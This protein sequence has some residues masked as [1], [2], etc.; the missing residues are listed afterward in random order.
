V[1]EGPPGRPQGRKS[2]GRVAELVEVPS[3]IELQRG[4][5]ARFLQADVPPAMRASV[6][7]QRA[8]SS[9]FPIRNLSETAALE[10]VGYALDPPKN[11]PNEC[12]TRGLTWSTPLKVTFRLVVWDPPEEGGAIR[13]IKEQ[14]V[15]LG[16]IPL[17]TPSGTFIINGTERVV[18]SQLHRSPGI[19][20][21][22]DRGRTHASG[23]LLYRARIIPER[24][25]WLDLEFDAKD[26]LHVR[27]DRRRKIP[28][29]V[30][31]RALG[32]STEEL[33]AYYYD[34]ETVFLEPGGHYSRSIR[35]DLLAGRRAT[36]DIVHPTT[37]ELLVR[38]NRKFTRQA[39]K[40]LADAGVDRLPLRAEDVVG[41]VAA[42]D[43][44]DPATGEV[45]LECNE[46]VR[47]ET[48]ELLRTSGITEFAVLVIDNLNVGG[49]VRNT[50]LVDRV[51]TP[52][53]ALEEF[54]RR[55]RPGQ[56]P[57]AAAARN[58]LDNLFFS[59]ARYDLSPVGRLKLNYKLKIDE[60]LETSTLTP[61]DILEAV[62]YLTE[63]RDG[64]G[65]LDDVDHLGNRR[66]RAVGELVERQFRVGLVRMERVIRERM[67]L[68]FDTPVLMPHDLVN[69][70]AVESALNEFFGSSQLSQ[71]ADQ[72]NPL[73]E[74]THKRR[75]SALGPG[76]LTR[77]Y[78]GFE[79]R[80]VHATHY[81]RLCPIETP[82]GQNVGLIVSLST[83][84]RVNDLG[85]IETP[86]RY[87][88]GGKPS[89]RVEFFSALQ[90]EGHYIAQ[91]S[92]PV[93]PDG[94]FSE[95]LVR[96]RHNG[97]FVM[98]RPEQVTL[99]DTAPSQLVSIAAALIPFL[100]HDDANRAL[101]GSNMQRQAM[102]LLRAR[103]PLV[104]TGMEGVVGRDSGAA[105]L[106]RRPGVVEQVEG[107]TVVVRP[108]A[109][110]D[111]E[112]D[113][114]ER[115][116]YP[117]VK[118][119]RSNQGSCINQRPVVSAGEW[120][121]AG[122]L[123]A[124]G[125]AMDRGELALGA[126]VVVA[127]MPWGGYNFEDSILISERLVKEDVLTSIHIEELE[128]AA[129]DTKLG[130]E[131]I[132][133]DIPNV[134]EA[135]LKELDDSGV[136]RIGAE[137]GAG[138]ILVGKVTPKG[139]TVL[140][141]E[142]KLLRAI[143]GQKAADVRDTSLRVPPGT[144][145]T[146][147]G[148]QVLTR[149]E[150]RRGRAAGELPPGVRMIVKV[151]IA[152]KRKLS[153]GDKLAGRHGNK[154]V[155]S[156]ILP[157]EDMPYLEDGTPVDIVLNP[158]GVPSRMNIGQILETHLGW[159]AREMGRALAALADERRSAD[160][161]RGRLRS[162][163]RE[164]PERRL[165]DQ[166]RAGEVRL[167][168]RRLREGVPLASP[169]FDGATEPDIKG[170]LAAAGL[171]LRGQA[172][173][174]D[175]RTG[176]PF[177]H[178]VTVGIMYVMKLHHLVDEKI[179]ARSIGPYSLVTQQPLGGKAQQGGQRLG[180]MEVWAMEGYGAAHALQEFLTVKSDDV[181]GRARTYEA[182]VQGKPIVEFG[183]P[184]SFHVLLKELQSLCLD[185][186]LLSA[187]GSER[188]AR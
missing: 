23:K 109:A 170:L 52:E 160:E 67:S 81:G 65:T 157:E 106:A 128:C 182:I 147:I 33:L 64:R 129:R 29:T 97:D 43:V 175:G 48:L 159:A 74:V 117:I 55:M 24:G 51:E 130:A 61:R 111:Q 15:L 11:D 30:L 60:P 46:A 167:W 5:Y 2:F 17:M 68:S 151:S 134:G 49:Y 156:R 173:V 161:L 101:M 87:V 108:R 85:F 174:F 53:E 31:L 104:G 116:V 79:V 58:L 41:S 32:Y 123:L 36:R 75:L 119:R 1:G 99:M 47:Q 152:T 131:E 145:G 144:R 20:Y 132:T 96:C 69:P 168:A 42:R 25:S 34:L 84:A 35:L 163:Y 7:L 21:G 113:Q 183:L 9:V 70:R 115:D 54:F 22:H 178:D 136:V 125:A 95:A 59:P 188:A 126:N 166:L 76:G 143:F 187:A 82:E 112:D 184:E 50:V 77:E 138:D 140:S 177:K 83:H 180:E 86:Y 72:T 172:T 6:G 171:P 93:G 63:L 45:L 90:E 176:E 28:A 94:H 165:L 39:L 149:G 4:S 91:A 120:V 19:F 56:V 44:F 185:V 18:V 127:F 80:D 122:A 16:E 169:V 10:F 66:V 26:L 73:S 8:F 158:L 148:S 146:V 3:L 124:D 57:T 142:E 14:E 141:P 162:V 135:A 154:G 107:R 27:V 118:F 179:H 12:R 114:D 186:E 71:L 103:A 137:V 164:G 100:E 133:R 105:V 181:N 110:A 13:D 88:E 78:A 62:R 40:K 98:A 89:E 38:R 92:T 139:E 150:G 155:V 121:E 153:V 37:G 102:P